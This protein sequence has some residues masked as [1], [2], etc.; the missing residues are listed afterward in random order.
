M[1]AEEARRRYVEF[2]SLFH[3]RLHLNLVA[4]VDESGTHDPTGKQLGSETLVIAGWVAWQDEWETF[5]VDWQEVLNRFNVPA[6]HMRELNNIDRLTNPRSPYFGWDQKKIDEFLGE[7]IPI[8]RD[9]TCLGVVG[10]LS[11][12]DYN[13]VVGERFKTTFDHPYFFAFQ[14]FFDSFLDAI[15]KTPFARQ[16]PVGEQIATFLDQQE[17]FGERAYAAFQDFKREKDFQNRMGSIT[18]ADHRKCLPL[19][20]ADL[21]AYRMRKMFTR[22]LQGLKPINSKSWD[23]ALCA[24]RNLITPYYDEDTLREL[25]ARMDKKKQQGVS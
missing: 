23:D 22:K 18:F 2:S 6:L 12:R 4:Y 24:R 1:S 3:E 8:A 5:C 10:L 14:L 20:A 11:V 13:N 19:Q 7:L 9:G 21:L 25:I 16:F 15:E 17:E